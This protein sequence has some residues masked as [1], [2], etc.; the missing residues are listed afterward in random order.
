MNISYAILQIKQKL[1]TAAQIAD[2]IEKSGTVHP[3]DVDC[4]LEE[5]RSTYN[6][7]YQLGW[8]EE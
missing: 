6:K 2:R 5:I 1:N 8:E 7:V 4:L 3:I